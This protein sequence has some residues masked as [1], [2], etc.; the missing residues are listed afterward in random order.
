M[1][2]STL[3]T[4][5]A[6]AASVGVI[7]TAAFSPSINRAVDKLIP[8]EMAPAWSLF[9]KFS[10]F[11]AAFTGGMPGAEPGRFIDRNAPL[12]TAPVEGENLMLVM[13]SIGGALTA[14]AWILLAFFA[15]TLLAAFSIRIWAMIKQRREDDATEGARVKAEQAEAKAKQDASES[16]RSETIKRMEPASTEPVK[17]QE[18][19]GT[20]PVKTEKPAAIPAPR[21]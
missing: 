8:E 10:L 15:V 12:V 16:P 2:T 7:A 9:M 1:D 20:R 14:S 13:R 17:R 18:P 19:A 21:P 6:A 4:A 3:V 11:V 5:Y